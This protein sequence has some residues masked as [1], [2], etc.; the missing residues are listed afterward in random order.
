MEKG[1]IIGQGFGKGLTAH[2][3]DLNLRHIHPTAMFGR[4]M[5]FKPLRQSARFLWRES[6][7]EGSGGV[8]VEIV[9]NQDNLFR[10]RIEYTRRMTENIGKINGCFMKAML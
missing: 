9:S 10:M 2:D 1:G 4:V 5:P 6:F 7:I 8:G 3:A